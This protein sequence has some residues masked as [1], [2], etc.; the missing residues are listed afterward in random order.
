MADAGGEGVTSDERPESTELAVVPPSQP[1]KEIPIA[2]F[3]GEYIR[4]MLCKIPA[5][6]IEMQAGYARGTHLKLEIEL[7]VRHVA[8]NETRGGEVERVHTMAYEDV[9]LIGAYMADEVSVGVG[10]N[11][12]GST[13]NQ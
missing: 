9:K 12:S 8:M 5:I 3:E 2:Q 4:T 13:G 1:A 6:S 10:G 11:A 7:R